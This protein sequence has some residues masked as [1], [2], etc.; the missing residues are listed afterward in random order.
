M[1]R[2]L[3]NHQN[4]QFFL[5]SENY[6]NTSFIK[7]LENFEKIFTKKIFLFKPCIFILIEF[8]NLGLN[9]LSKVNFI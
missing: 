5:E 9:P 3:S 2:S 6:N 8:I 1:L 4:S 7:V